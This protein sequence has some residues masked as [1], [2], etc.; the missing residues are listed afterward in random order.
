MIFS[1][2]LSIEFSRFHNL[3]RI[4]GELTQSGSG[5]FFACNYCYFF[6]HLYIDFFNFYHLISGL[7]R[8]EFQN[9]FK[10]VVFC[11]MTRVADLID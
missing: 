3:V 11:Q 5:F 6:I 8:I 1:I 4:F 2:F 10:F 7:L 9:I